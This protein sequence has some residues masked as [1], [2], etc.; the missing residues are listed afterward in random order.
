[1]AAEG[2]RLAERAGLLD[3]IC[4]RCCGTPAASGVACVS[5]DCPVLF[6]RARVAQQINDHEVTAADCERLLAP[7]IARAQEEE[8]EKEEWFIVDDDE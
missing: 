4:G 1:M 8:K 7:Y 6:E 2:G 5:L 3:R